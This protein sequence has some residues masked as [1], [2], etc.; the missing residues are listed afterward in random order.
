MAAN[1]T[2]L[3]YAQNVFLAITIRSNSPYFK[4]PSSI[5]VHASMKYYGT[6]GELTDVL[7]CAVPRREWPNVKQDVMAALS[8]TGSVTAVEVQDPKFKY[9]RDDL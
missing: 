3:E 5:A 4:K 8:R 9:K 1:P 2:D 6:V 7:L